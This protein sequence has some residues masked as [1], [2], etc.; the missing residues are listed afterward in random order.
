MKK[1][2]LKTGHLVAR[3]IIVMALVSVTI[4]TMVWLG[5]TSSGKSGRLAGAPFIINGSR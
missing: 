2:T 3:A 1:R 4:F 5:S